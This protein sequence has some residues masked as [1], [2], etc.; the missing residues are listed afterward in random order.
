MSSSS[1][2]DAYLFETEAVNTPGTVPITIVIPL[3]ND[4][5]AI[6]LDQNFT[7]EDRTPNVRDIHP[8]E[9]TV[10]GGTELTVVGSNFEAESNPQMNLTQKAIN[11]LDGTKTF[12]EVKYPPTPCSVLKQSE[13]TCKTPELQLPSSEEFGSFKAEYRFGFIFDGFEDR[14]DFEGNITSEITVEIAVVE[15]HSISEHHWPPYDAT[16]RQP[17]HIEISWGHFQHEAVVRVGGIRSNI[18]ERFVNRLLFLPPD[19]AQLKPESGCKTSKEAHSVEVAAGNT[20]RHV[21]C[22]TYDP[23]D[24]TPLRMILVFAVCG[25]VA[26]VVVASII[27]FYIVQKRKNKDGE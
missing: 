19:E 8:K 15:L 24:D 22:L 25:V 2:W 20:N 26:V 10:H 1:Q 13:M 5:H 18:T 6:T 11:T 27:A 17:L 9:L 7:F 21:G 4:I 23:D 16:R 12:D 14:Q 3:R